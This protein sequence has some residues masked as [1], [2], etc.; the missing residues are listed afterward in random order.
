MILPFIAY[1]CFPPCLLTYLRHASISQ[2][3][4]SY[5]SLPP[6]YKGSLLVS[7]DPKL[8]LVD[9]LIFYIHSVNPKLLKALLSLSS[10]FALRCL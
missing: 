7:L 8:D 2:T 9:L 10:P 6:I 5:L 3:Y 1:P 4:L